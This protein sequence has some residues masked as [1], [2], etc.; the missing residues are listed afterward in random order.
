MITNG[1]DAVAAIK[2]LL[3]RDLKQEELRVRADMAEKVQS[4]L[5]AIGLGDRA[6]DVFQLYRDAD[7]EAMRRRVEFRK[8]DTGAAHERSSGIEAVFAG[9]MRRWGALDSETILSFQ[10]AHEADYTKFRNKLFQAR[11]RTTHVKAVLRPFNPRYM[12]SWAEARINGLDFEKEQRNVEALL[13]Q[14]IENEIHLTSWAEE[15]YR[16]FQRVAV[17]KN[18]IEQQYEMR[19]DK[20]KPLGAIGARSERTYSQQ[21]SRWFNENS[22]RLMSENFEPQASSGDYQRNSYEYSP[23]GARAPLSYSS[24]YQAQDAP[25]V[26]TE[27]SDA[28]IVRAQAVDDA[29]LAAE[30]SFSS[31]ARAIEEVE[32]W[33]AYLGAVWGDSRRIVGLEIEFQSGATTYKNKLPQSSLD[34]AASYVKVAI[35]AFGS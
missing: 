3:E 33:F 14:P 28:V 21:W 20:N 26:A 17:L 15:V 25:V 31:R 5:D 18:V 1:R 10:K 7:M 12:D 6:V 29:S 24:S 19:P 8:I 32:K 34:G 9:K 13:A 35:S 2:L 27:P 4:E 30:S 22:S 16:L 23:Q 11:I